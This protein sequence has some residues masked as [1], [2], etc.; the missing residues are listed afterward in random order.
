MG[1]G[2]V[3]FAIPGDTL[4]EKLEVLES[5]GMW[6]ELANDGKKHVKEIREVMASYQVPIKS[7]QAFRQHEL[8]LLSADLE[9]R[10]L[11]YRHITETI[12]MAAELGAE[13]VVVVVGYGSPGVEKPEEACLNFFKEFGALGKELGVFISIEPL[14]SKTSF[15]PTV[16]DIS[17]LIRKSISEN[18]R[19]LIDTMHVESCGENPAEIIRIYS[20]EAE[21]VQLRDTD[22]KPPGKGKIDFEAVLASLQRFQGLV[23]LEYKPGQDPLADFELACKIC[24]EVR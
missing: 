23:C 13:N 21:E 14:G 8:Q 4:K 18:L 17:Q 15:L 12:R 22:S 3:E 6:L 11:A 2:C 1:C 7:V 20:G 24:G 9:E 5:R 19:L 16:S 10:N